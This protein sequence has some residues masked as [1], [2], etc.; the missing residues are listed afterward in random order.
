M[1][2]A[3][4]STKCVPD[5]SADLVIVYVRAIFDADPVLL[6]RVPLATVHFALQQPNKPSPSSLTTAGGGGSSP[7]T[8]RRRL[9]VSAMGSATESCRITAYCTEAVF[10]ACVPRWW[11][12]EALVQCEIRTAADG[13]VAENWECATPSTR[14][15]NPNW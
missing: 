3:D 4:A 7:S 15:C 2:N 12:P 14:R 1:A 6:S 5:E 8:T 11:V 9:S 10:A 13:P